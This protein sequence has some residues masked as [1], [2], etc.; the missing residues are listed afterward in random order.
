MTQV[1][2]ILFTTDIAFIIVI[3]EQ[4]IYIILILF[5]S[6]FYPDILTKL[7]EV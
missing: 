7:L 6:D 1:T 3:Y 2:N 4:L 5:F